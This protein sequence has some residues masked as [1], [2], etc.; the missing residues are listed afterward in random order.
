MG[1]P[2]YV[3]VLAVL[4]VRIELAVEPEPGQIVGLHRKAEDLGGGGQS[5]VKHYGPLVGMILHV[6]RRPHH[7]PEHRARFKDGVVGLLVGSDLDLVVV[8]QD[9]PKPDLADVVDH[10]G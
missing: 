6:P 5:V 10:I 9:Q 2:A 4:V 8:A 1:G 7:G 3:G